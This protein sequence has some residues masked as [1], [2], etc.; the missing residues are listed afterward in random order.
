MK[1]LIIS[2]AYPPMA[3]G[4]ATNAS[5]LAARM[6]DWGVDVNVLTR[7]ISGAPVHRGVTVHA[8]MATWDWLDE[9]P[10]RLKIRQI[11]PDAVLFMHLGAMY[12]M[13]PM[14]T[15][16][17]SF[18][19]RADPGIRVVTRFENPRSQAEPH[20]LSVTSRLYR[21]SVVLR[22]GRGRTHYTTGTLLRDSDAVICLCEDHRRFLLEQ[23]PAAAEKMTVLPPPANVEV[24]PD[25]DGT[26]RTSGRRRL[27]V[28]DHEFLVGYLGYIYRGKGLE[29][30]VDALAQ[31][32]TNG[33]KVRLLVLGGPVAPSWPGDT[34]GIDYHATVRERSKAAGVDDLVHWHGPFDTVN[35]DVASLLHAVD[36]FALPFDQGVQLNNSS[37]ASLAAYG[38]AVVTTRSQTT[39]PQFID[40]KNVLLCEPRRSSAIAAALG[41]LFDDPHLLQTLRGGVSELSATSYNW[42]NALEVT[43][44][45]LQSPPREPQQLLQ[46]RQRS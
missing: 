46:M 39:D 20:R 5:H 22:C 14:M 9:I 41:T 12:D 43:I 27:G 35:Q 28:G 33:R 25:L 30:L 21:R 13:H 29:N 4:E 6:A 3:F 24:I 37:I 23:D 36:V 15:F 45:L 26:L 32:R 40:R 7:R 19:K 11:R 2:G 42:N 8:D 17:P 34:R 10:L 44:R 38:A 31:L 16:L 1:V 18:V